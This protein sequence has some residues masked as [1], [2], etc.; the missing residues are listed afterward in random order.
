M[1]TSQLSNYAPEARNDFI[2]AV[3]AQAAKL[4][5]TSKGNAPAEVQGDVLL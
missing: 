5:I 2:A 3:S 4:G 1:N